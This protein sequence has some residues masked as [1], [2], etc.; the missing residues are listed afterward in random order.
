MHHRRTPRK[1][2]RGLALLEVS[3]SPRQARA[4]SGAGAGC[5]ARF[6]YQALRANRCDVQY[7]RSSNKRAS[8]NL[9]LIEI[10]QITQPEDDAAG[11]GATGAVENPVSAYSNG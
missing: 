7:R 2:P 9:T 3:G 5:P 4:V 11:A 1:D 6:L 8:W 10:A